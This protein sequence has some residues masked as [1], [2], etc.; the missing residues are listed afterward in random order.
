ME[1]TQNKK[2]KKL[3]YMKNWRAN[4]KDRIKEYKK[5]YDSENKD[6][7][8]EYNQTPNRKKGQRIF[9]WKRRGLVC[10]D[11]NKLY[12]HYIDTNECNVCNSGFTDN[13]KRCM[14]H[15][16]ATGEFR[17]I[18]CNRCNVMDNWK[19]RIDK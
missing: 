18:L 17:A 8:K 6:K 11:Y 3:E 5:K 16:H 15:D 4:N 2:Q 1:S 10:D 14:D 12:Q 7:I 9:D 13:N 19:K